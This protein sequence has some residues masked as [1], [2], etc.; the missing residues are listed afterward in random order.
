MRRVADVDGFFGADTMN[1]EV[2]YDLTI[3]T[4]VTYN[5]CEFDFVAR[6]RIINRFQNV[7]LRFIFSRYT[8]TLGSF[9]IPTDGPPILYPTTDDTYFIGRDFRVKYNWSSITP[10]RDREINPV[11]FSFEFIYDYEWNV[12]NY[13]FYFII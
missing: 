5:L 2:T 9:I 4:D 7:E 12:F 11:G 8:A 6:H 1:G 3:P 13:N 10:T